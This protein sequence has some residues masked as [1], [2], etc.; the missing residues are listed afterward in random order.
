V[1]LTR[2]PDDGRASAVYR[3]ILDAVGDRVDELEPN[4]EVVAHW[5]F[6]GTGFRGLLVAGQALDGWDAE[7][8]P[9]RW[10]L[11][12]MRDPT[13]REGLLHGAQE[14]ARRLPEPIEEV[15]TRSNRSGKPFWDVTG[16]IVSAIEP[17]DGDPS[18]W[19]SRCAW[20]NVYPIAPRR[21]SPGG[22]LKELQAPFVGEL[23][24]A[25]V[26]EL[27]VDRVVLVAG[28]GWWWDVRARL[29]LAGLHTDH[30]KPVIASGRTRG[31]SV[32]YSY[33]PGGRL[34]GPR[35]AVARAVAEALPR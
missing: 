11:E 27:G 9:A 17:E 35:D 34:R 31:V 16:R 18:P 1:S 20:F 33:H 19:Y 29:G 8:T 6:V 22:L 14:W 28:K 32:V 26:E 3:K 23:F 13:N 12:Q 5:P 25:V 2:L 10:R 24:W 7:V 30:L 4:N 15:M 21:G